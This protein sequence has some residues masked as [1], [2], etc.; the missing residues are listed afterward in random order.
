MTKFIYTKQQPVW[1]NEVYFKAI[2]YARSLRDSGQDW[3]L[4]KD[5]RLY[6]IDTRDCDTAEQFAFK[7]SDLIEYGKRDKVLDWEQCVTDIF[8]SKADGLEPGIEGSL[9]YACKIEMFGH[10]W[11]Q[12]EYS[13]TVHGVHTAWLDLATIYKLDYSWRKNTQFNTFF[14]QE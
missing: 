3:D 14:T 5:R 6:R 12:D 7:C 2:D 8:D 1:D 13:R 9:I 11:G 4:Y 10:K